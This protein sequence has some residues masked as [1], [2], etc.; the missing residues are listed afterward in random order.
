MRRPH[1]LQAPMRA[2]VSPLANWWES[3]PE[4]VMVQA[5]YRSIFRFVVQYQKW[6]ATNRA[7]VAAVKNTKI[8]A[9][10][11]RNYISKA[12]ERRRSPRRKR[13]AC[14]RNARSRTL[15]QFVSRDLERVPVGIAKID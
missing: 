8:A 4:M 13:S 14:A 5:R 12:A 9:G 11:P 6:A 1:P 15:G 10:A 7:P 3:R 2:C